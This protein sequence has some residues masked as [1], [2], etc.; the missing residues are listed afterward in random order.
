MLVRA[1]P[2][3]SQVLYVHANGVLLYEVEASTDA[4]RYYHADQ[5]GN[6]VALSDSS[7]RVTDRVSYTPFGSIAARSGSSDT[8]FL[9]GGVL[10]CATD[11]NGLVS[12]RARFY[13]P[14]LARFVNSDPNGA[15]LAR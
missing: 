12:M 15:K 9:F 10:G 7:G 6:T 3:G 11:A 8:P 2:N 4:P 13:Q 5:V 14:K 1:R